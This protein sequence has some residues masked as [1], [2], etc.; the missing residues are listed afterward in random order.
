MHRRRLLILA[1]ICLFWTGLVVVAHFYANVPFLSDV[2]RGEQSFEDLL[3]REGRK[4][5][6]SPDLVFVGIDQASLDLTD[7][8]LPDEIKTNRAF[9]L[10]TQRPFPWSREVW[11]LFMD[12][13]FQA[14][15]RLV[16][17]DLVFD[18]PNDGDPQLSRKRSI[19]IGTK[20]WSARI[21][22]S[23]RRADS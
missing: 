13:V 5:P 15:A 12:R 2:W 11:G 20:L 10:M 17:F 4:T 18:R 9:Q 21:S 3:R 14:G 22:I 6:T 8:A 23:H 16:I 1:G 7:T 19:D